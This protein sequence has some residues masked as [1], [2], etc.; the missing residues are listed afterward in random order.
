[1]E[2]NPWKTLSSH[3]IYHTPWFSVRED[4]VLRPDGS[5]GTYSVVEAER[6]AVGV[7]PL[8][9]DS[10]ITLVGQFRYPIGE[11]SWE[12]PEGGGPLTGDPL[13]SAKQELKEETGIE[14]RSWEYL[15]RVHTSNCFVSEVCHLYVATDLQQ[16]TP[17]PG[18]DEQLI[19]RRV[20]VGDAIAMAA[21]GRITDGISIAGLFRLERYLRVV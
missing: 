7:L 11:Y 16:G 4:R 15:G 12:I 14:A 13:P 5:P 9:P 2:H 18:A 20:A 10:T 17:C 6:L 3:Q 8:W 1:M 21:D 19:T